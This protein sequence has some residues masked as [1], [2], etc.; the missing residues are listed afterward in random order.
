[1]TENIHSFTWVEVDVVFDL[2]VASVNLEEA[3]DTV[4][5]VIIH[6]LD[7]I[8]L[9]VSVRFILELTGQSDLVMLG[10]KI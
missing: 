9:V 10:G 6:H 7:L 4:T 8:D 2:H 3:R 5:V 1:M